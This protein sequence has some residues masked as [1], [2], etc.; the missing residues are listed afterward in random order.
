[1][2]INPRGFWIS[3]SLEGHCYDHKLVEALGFLLTFMEVKTVVDLGCGPGW[4]VK[5][6][7]D[8]GFYVGGF[9][10]NPYTKEISM[11]ILQDG[12]YCEQLDLTQGFELEVP[13]DLILSLE[14]GEHIPVKYEEVFIQNLVRNTK[15]YIIVS[16][17]TEGQ[18]GDG[19]INCR[20]ND[21]V[22]RK[23]KSYGFAENVPAK[24]FLR[25]RACLDW[26]RK[27]IMVFQ[28]I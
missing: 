2:E 23:I 5:A 19:H 26:F 10:G 6:L 25:K 16:W 9:D 7:R 28:K 1:M 27:T 4:Y 18:G 24:N 3:N 22:I 15:N 11:G 12:I 17:A 13:V 20:S 8:K 14:V 21:Y